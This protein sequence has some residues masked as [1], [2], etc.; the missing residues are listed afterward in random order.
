[1]MN[2]PSS[3][4]YTAVD[5]LSELGVLILQFTDYVTHIVTSILHLVTFR[6]SHTYLVFCFGVPVWS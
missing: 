1:M 2:V 6:L 3:P 5:T 4:L